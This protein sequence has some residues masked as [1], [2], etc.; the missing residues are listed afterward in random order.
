MNYTE[1]TLDYFLFNGNNVTFEYKEG[2]FNE[3]GDDNNG[4][5]TGNF[6]YTRGTLTPSTDGYGRL[7]GSANIN[8]NDWNPNIDGVNRISGTMYNKPVDP[9]REFRIGVS[10]GEQGNRRGFLSDG[11]SDG[12]DPFGWLSGGT[13]N[14]TID[15]R[16]FSLYELSALNSS[17]NIL[18]IKGSATF[19]QL[20][21]TLS[22]ISFLFNLP[23]GRY[24]SCSDTQ[25]MWNFF[26]SHIDQTLQITIRTP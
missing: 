15:G 21:V 19:S 26:N 12:R 17:R 9:P 10:N 5:I 25:G 8:R 3:N 4:S 18:E 7:H 6:T 23:N 20:I 22:G 13:K 1:S 14:F 11:Y 24:G 16:T 2:Q